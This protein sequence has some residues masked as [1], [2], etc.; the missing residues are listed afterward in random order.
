MIDLRALWIAGALF[1][2]GNAA[3][4]GAQSPG[5]GLAPA[6]VQA[7]HKVIQGQIEAFRRDDAEAA[8]ALASPAIQARFGT[9]ANFLGMVRAGYQA[10]YRPRQYRFLDITPAYGEFVQ[11]V[12]VTGPDGRAV[13]AIYPMIKLKDGSWRTDGCALVP[14]EATD[15]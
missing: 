11:K 9:A 1:L 13:M 2:V 6:D 5:G 3:T 10:V 12:L 14:L 7:V 4:A 15:A 8:F